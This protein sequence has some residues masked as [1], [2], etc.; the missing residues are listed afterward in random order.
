MRISNLQA[1]GLA[2]AIGAGS[3]GAHAKSLGDEALLTSSGVK[4]RPQFTGPLQGASLAEDATHIPW[5]DEKSAQRDSA[6]DPELGILGAIVGLAGG[7]GVAAAIG[8]GLNKNALQNGDDKTIDPSQMT[9]EKRG[10][11]RASELLWKD[12]VFF[13]VPVISLAG[14]TAG[15]AYLS[16][17]LKG[18]E[19]ISFRTTVQEVLDGGRFGIDTRDEQIFHTL[20]LIPQSPVPLTAASIG[21]PLKPGDQIEARFNLDAKKKILSWSAKPVEAGN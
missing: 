20:L 1:I 13:T 10:K 16:S 14:G 18:G 7:V 17:Y 9:E 11:A 6:P 12:L 21:A 4:E 5:K 8:R 2:T 3:V 15:A 19:V